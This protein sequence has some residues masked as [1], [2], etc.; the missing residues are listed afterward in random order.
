[1]IKNFNFLF[2][3]L[4]GLGKIKHAP[5][6]IA[7]LFTCAFFLIIINY[8][9]LSI[10]SFLT[11]IIFL[12]SLIAINNSYEIFNSNDPQEI[13]IDEFVGQM[14]PLLGFPIYETLYPS[15][16][17]FYCILAFVIFRFFDIL[18]PYP[19]NII[20]NNTKGSLG[21]MLDDIVAGL[22]TII[23]LTILFFFIGG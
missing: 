7:S 18:K 8:F 3:T 11:L 17:E 23:I 4:C 12:Y 5:G 16:N 20:D 15:S 6:T 9:S 22:F 2:V 1:M 19:I 13:V 14:I 21:I 10:I